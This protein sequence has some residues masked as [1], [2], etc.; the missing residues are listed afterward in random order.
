MTAAAPAAWECSGRDEKTAPQPNQKTSIVVPVGERFS[1]H[2]RRA[3]LRRP[4][5]SRLPLAATSGTEAES[6]VCLV[7]VS[8]GWGSVQLTF[9]DMTQKWGYS[10]ELLAPESAEEVVSLFLAGIDD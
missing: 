5:G 2:E 8:Q 1:D 6:W 9:G 4:A 7:F 3:S 10:K